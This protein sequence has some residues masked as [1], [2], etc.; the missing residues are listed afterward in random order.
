MWSCERL[1]ACLP[2][3]LNHFIFRSVVGKDFCLSRSHEVFVAL[4]LAQQLPYWGMKIF[5]PSYILCWQVRMLTLNSLSE[6]WYYFKLIIQRMYCVHVCVWT[7]V[8]THT[9]T[10]IIEVRGHF[11]K[12]SSLLPPY[13]FRRMKLGHQ[14]WPQASVLPRAL[15]NI[16]KNESAIFSQLTLMGTYTYECGDLWSHAIKPSGFEN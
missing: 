9:M 5:F 3:Q 13:G 1:P 4:N 16:P 11:D 14:S 7:Q 12:V 6:T 8:H 2:K 15:L 10:C